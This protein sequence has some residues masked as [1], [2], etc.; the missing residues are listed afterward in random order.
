MNPTRQ[1]IDNPTGDTHIDRL[2]GVPT[3]GDLDGLRARNQSRALQSIRK[4]GT[5]YVCHPANS[6]KNISRT[7]PPI[8]KPPRYLLRVA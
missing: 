7:P 8:S 3:Q 6:P 4:L 2:R 5:R 1:T